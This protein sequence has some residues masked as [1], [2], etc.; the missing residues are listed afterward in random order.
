MYLED[1]SGSEMAEVTGFS[2]DAV[3][4]RIHRVKRRLGQWN[5]GDP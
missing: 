4:V 5:A 1:M 2:H 3:R